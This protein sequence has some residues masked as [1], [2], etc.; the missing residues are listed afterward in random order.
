[1]RQ[2]LS[3]NRC[4]INAL[5]RPLEESNAQ[6][7]FELLNLAAQRRLAHVARFRGAAKVAM[8]GDCDEITKFLEIHICSRGPGN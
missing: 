4:E 8:I 2:N 3:A 5:I 6:L 7:V 1:V